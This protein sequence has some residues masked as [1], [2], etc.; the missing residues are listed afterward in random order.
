[1]K[2]ILVYVMVAMMVVAPMNAALGT[3]ATGQ[4]IEVDVDHPPTC[5]IACTPTNGI[6]FTG[7][8]AS[9]VCTA[10]I[11]EPDDGTLTYQWY[12]DAVPITGSTT[13]TLSI[14]Q[15]Y[16]VNEG[17]FMC[18]AT[19]SRGLWTDSNVIDLTVYNKL[20]VMEQPVSQDINTNGT[21]VLGILVLG[22]TPYAYQW[23]KDGTAAGNAIAGAT[24]DQYVKTNAQPAD[25]GTYYCY[26]TDGVSQSVWSLGAVVTV[27]LPSAEFK[28]THATGTQTASLVVNQHN[29]QLSGQVLSPGLLPPSPVITG[30]FMVV[31]DGGLEYVS[32]KPVAVL[33]DGDSAIVS[34]AGATDFATWDGDSVNV[35][36]AKA[37]LKIS[38]GYTVNPGAKDAWVDV[39]KVV[40]SCN[41]TA[42]DLLAPYVNWIP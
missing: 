36:L 34:F 32:R 42:M 29:V 28:F 33:A 20:T 18:R 35:N 26:V 22:E 23:Y 5:S 8:P 10:A 41:G 16:N 40:L 31:N 2:Q 1:M 14:S 6:V 17:Q 4:G 11:A 9:F 21:I 27:G 38:A 13:S 30:V 37:G 24:D 15:V 12:F 7:D 3:T 19:N 25:A 39:N